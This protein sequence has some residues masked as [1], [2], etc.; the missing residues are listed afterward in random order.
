M[1]TFITSD[2]HFSH[3]NIPK[4][5]PWSRG[6]FE[7]DIEAMD[8]FII[9]TWNRMISPGDQVYIIGDVFFCNYGKAIQLLGALNGKL[10]LVYGNHDKVI[11]KNPELQN[12]FSGGLHE[13]LEVRY[14][15]HMIVMFHYPILEWNKMHHGS[16][17]FYGHLHGSKNDHK[18][19]CKDVGLD[20]NNCKPY[21]LDDAIA[22]TLKK[23][24]ITHHN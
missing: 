23:P 3:K 18:G 9:K 7:G 10:T 2:I 21:L 22:E 19:R 14:N 4:F 20:T 16:I 1:N 12:M 11:R 17:H 15:G 6:E 24:I 8:R 5:C 13:Y